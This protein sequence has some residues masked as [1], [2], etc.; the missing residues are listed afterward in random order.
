MNETD[1]SNRCRKFRKQTNYVGKMHKG[2]TSMEDKP[3]PHYMNFGM[4]IN[5][6]RG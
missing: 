3:W 5:T 4:E 6:N 1:W 2:G